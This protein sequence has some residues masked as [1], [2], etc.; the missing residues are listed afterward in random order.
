[1]RKVHR[2]WI[3]ADRA[4]PRTAPDCQK[5]PLLRE[6][7]ELLSLTT[8]RNGERNATRCTRL[9]MAQAVTWDYTPAQMDRIRQW[10]QRGAKKGDAVIMAHLE[11]AA[12][13]YLVPEDRDFLK[14]LPA[15]PFTVLSSE[16]AVRLLGECGS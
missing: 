1:V 15:L 12:V 11:G 2:Q 14:E 8:H 3:V 10:E 5:R 13:R 4:E 9:T 7:V 16:E 6:E